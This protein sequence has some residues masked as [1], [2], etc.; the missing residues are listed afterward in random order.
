MRV[1]VCVFDAYGTLFD[2]SAAAR[3]LAAEPG[4]EGFAAVWPRLSELWRA[5]QLS[6]TWLRTAAGVHADFETVTREAL[7]WAAEAVGGLA[8]EDHAALMAL[9]RRL[10]AYPEVPG[11]LAALKAAGVRTAILSNGAPGMLAAAVDGAGIGDRL[12]AVLSAESVGRFKPA[13]EVYGL[14]GRRFG[15][16]AGQVLFVSS[17]GWDVAAAAGWGFR[18]LWAN[19]AAEPVE[20]LPWRPE[21][22][23][24]DLTGVPAMA[25]ALTT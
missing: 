1:S 15:V 14:V 7:D 23:A 16:A 10:D 11:V 24:P 18:T 6:Y 17:N 2:V 22:I 8:P 19:R 13:P 9:Y 3:R 12:D 21:R 25:A 20:R 5:K 4:R